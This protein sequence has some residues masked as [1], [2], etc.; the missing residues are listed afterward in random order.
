MSTI[1]LNGTNLFPTD[2]PK[3]KSKVGK[4][5]VNANGGRVFLHRTTT[6]GTPI[7][8]SQWELTWADATEA[9]RTAIEAFAH[10]VTTMVFVDQHGTSYTVQTEEDAYDDSVS[11]IAGDG[12]LYY[13]VTLTLKEA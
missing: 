13:R 4:T 5:Q 9:Q 1:T 12:S 3:K 6:G 7:F 2:A 11:I 10:V 8:K